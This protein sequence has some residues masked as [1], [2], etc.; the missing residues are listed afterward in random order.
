MNGRT[1]FA[2]RFARSAL[3]LAIGCAF[4]LA[5]PVATAGTFETENVK[6]SFDST[7]SLGMQWRM[8][9]TD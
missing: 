5:S 1:H 4:G 6:G 3:A 9:G 7:I 8:S 2:P